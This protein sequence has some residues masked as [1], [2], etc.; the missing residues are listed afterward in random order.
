MLPFELVALVLELG[1]ILVVRQVA[2]EVL[3]RGVLRRVGGS[4]STAET[5]LLT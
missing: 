4:E 2:V 5:L 3:A 1:L